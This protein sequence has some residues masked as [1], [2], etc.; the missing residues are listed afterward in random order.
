MKMSGK[1][2]GFCLLG[3]AAVGLS[4]VGCSEDSR[5]WWSPFPREVEATLPSLA[6]AEAVV[7]EPMGQPCCV[8]E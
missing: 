6:V 4:L 1:I 8:C 7:V 5:S 2:T 3:V